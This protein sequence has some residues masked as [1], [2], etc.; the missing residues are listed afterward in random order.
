MALGIAFGTRPEWL[1]V[2]PVVDEL[3]KQDVAFGLIFTGQHMSLLAGVCK[4]YN[5]YLNNV[6][7]TSIDAENRLDSIVCSIIDQADELEEFTSILVQGDTTSAFACA[8]TAFHREIPVI[9]L[10]AGLR[11]DDPTQPFPEEANRR[12]I[13]ALAK[14]HLCPTE[15]AKQNLI[16]ERISKYGV[17]EVV[18][19]TVLDSIKDV[20]TTIEK[21][22]L[23]TMHRR[24]NHDELDEWFSNIDALAGTMPDYKFILPIHPNPKV[25]KHREAFANVEVV[26]PMSHE[27]LIEI[28]ASCSYVITD[29]GGIQEEASFLRKPTMVCRKETERKEGLNNFSYL[30]KTPKD[31]KVI[32]ETL[33]DLKMIGSSPYGDGNSAKK[34]VDA[35]KRL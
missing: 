23:V 3:I 35:I 7:I 26:E 33:S 18:G 16:E 1:K 13:A 30:C 17:I 34:V 12:M 11:T 22:V 24:E 32:F 25:L 6:W 29:S 31:V 10:E 14:V 21:K 8:L 27:K 28:L 19:N 15:A 2:L 4:E 9:H 20:K 5:E